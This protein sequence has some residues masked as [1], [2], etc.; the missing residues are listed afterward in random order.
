MSG[1]LI[2]WP[3]F[4]FTFPLVSCSL[5]SNSSFVLGFICALLLDIDSLPCGVCFWAWAVLRWVQLALLSV[6]ERP[7]AGGASATRPDTTLPVR[8]DLAGRGIVRAGFARRRDILGAR[9]LQQ[10]FGPG[11]LV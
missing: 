3:T 7:G 8:R 4:S 6:P 5:P 10:I 1:L 11:Y 2:A 9:M